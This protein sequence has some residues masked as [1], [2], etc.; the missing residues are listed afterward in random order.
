MPGRPT[1]LF[2]AKKPMNVVMFRGILE[3]LRAE[4][5]VR[6]VL[7]GKL[8]GTGA[9]RDLY[10]R[11][12]LAGERTVPTWWARHRRYDVY[13]CPDFGI[14]GRR[15]RVKVQIFHGVSL[16]NYAIN[17]RLRRFDKVFVV[18]EYMRR[19]L[20]E[21][22]ILEEDDPRI[23]RVGMP[24]LDALV[25]GSLRRDEVLAGLGLDPDRP[26]VLY[27]PTWGEGS[28]LEAWGTE[29]LEALGRLPV[30]VLVKLHDNSYDRRKT[31]VDWESAIRALERPDF[32]QIR[33]ASVLPALVAADVLVSDASS[34]ANEFLLLDRPIVFADCPE[35]L[36]SLEG[37]ADLETWGRRTGRVA[38]AQGE[39]TTAVERAL[40]DPAEHG[41]VRA[42]AARDLFYEPGRATERAVACLLRYAGVP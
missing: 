37:R 33:D 13:V 3:R 21:R 8:M 16:K 18:G 27:A 6:C 20:V 25:D 10:A 24:K 4:G 30:Q 19:T 23:E 32:L 2:Y 9:A 39:L 35:L 11:A 28:S 7:A 5:R 1:I 22:G 31:T 12:G 15:C 38:G 41:E 34:V 17:Q 26:V 14:L 29:I 42:A 36:E 40:A